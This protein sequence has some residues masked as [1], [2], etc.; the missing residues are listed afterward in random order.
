[1][2]KYVHVAGTGDQ[3]RTLGITSYGQLT[4][5]GKK[6][7]LDCTIYCISLIHVSG[8]GFPFFFL[9]CGTWGGGVT[10]CSPDPG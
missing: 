3:T 5:P 7:Y 1:M 4:D 2:H 10:H 8:G 9:R 6:F